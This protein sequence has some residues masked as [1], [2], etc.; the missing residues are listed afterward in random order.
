M[1]LAASGDDRDRFA[2]DEVIACHAGETPGLTGSKVVLRVL[3][4]NAVG[5]I[6]TFDIPRQHVGDG[7]PVEPVHTDLTGALVCGGHGSVTFQPGCPYTATTTVRSRPL[8]DH[9]PI[10]VLPH[11][12]MIARYDGL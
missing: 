7:A 11:S 2:I 8:S 5:G 9:T 10:S 3:D 12:C 4:Q 6:E 1:S